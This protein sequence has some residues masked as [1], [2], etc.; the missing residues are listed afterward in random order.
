[1]HD[2]R[3]GS[4]LAKF[5]DLLLSGKTIAE[6]V[7]LPGGGK[8]DGVTIAKVRRVLI[9]EGRLKAEDSPLQRDEKRAQ[10][11]VQFHPETKAFKIKALFDAG[12]TD[13]QIIASGY[14]KVDLYSVRTQIKRK[15]DAGRPG[16]AMVLADPKKLAKILKKNGKANG[17][18]FS[19]E[20]DV[21]VVE[22]VF[23]V[24]GQGEVRVFAS[25]DV[26]PAV[27]ARAAKVTGL[28]K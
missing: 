22:A 20:F 8:H 1:M 27:Y 13:E 14:T 19:P 18:A 26:F 3:P 4:Q 2:Y 23:H 15:T 5:A 17:H 11:F 7:K 21:P 25:V 28:I 16:K 9:E 6:I 24:P 10:P 12:K